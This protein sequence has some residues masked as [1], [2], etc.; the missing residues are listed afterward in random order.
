MHTGNCCSRWIAR[1]ELKSGRNVCGFQISGRDCAGIIS[2][3]R[4]DVIF[5]H[6][7]PPMS[8]DDL[9][10]LP[11]DVLR[12]SILYNQWFAELPDVP[13][14]GEYW[15]ASPMSLAE[16]GRHVPREKCACCSIRCEGNSSTFGP[17]PT[18]CHR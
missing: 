13:E 3:H 15:F 16:T 7:Y 17:G 18:V 5:W 2:E 14:L 9:A 12:R 11:A 1:A 4:P 8:L 10:G 6:W